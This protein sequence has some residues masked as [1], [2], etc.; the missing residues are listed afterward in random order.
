MSTKTDQD[1][2]R[3]GVGRVDTASRFYVLYRYEYGAG[4]VD[5]GEA[6]I[7]AKGLGVELTGD[8]SL[9]DRGRS[10]IVELRKDEVFARDYA[11][12][13]ADPELGKPGPLGAPPLV[14]VLQRLLWLL[15]N[16][17][18]ETRNFLDQSRPDLERL[19]LLAN[20]L[21]GRAL[22]GGEGDEGRTDEQKAVDRLLAQWRRVVEEG[23][24]LFA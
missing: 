5:F 21:K 10:S 9:S 1:H 8:G 17:P 18:A 16:K 6:N 3:E 20:A 2:P 24:G 12:R 14:D 19:R 15:E 22:S 4:P 23:G 11:A 7:L 13:G